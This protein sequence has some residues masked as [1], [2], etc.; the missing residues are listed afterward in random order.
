MWGVR[1]DK[2]NAPLSARPRVK[3]VPV[4]FARL[5]IATD[6]THEGLGCA[7]IPSKTTRARTIACRW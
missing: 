3:H 2:L 1:Y 6:P 5:A 4:T 7:S